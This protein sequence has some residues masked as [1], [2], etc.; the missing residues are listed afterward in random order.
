VQTGS[1]S[2]LFTLITALEK[3]VPFGFQLTFPDG[4]GKRLTKLRRRARGLRR[5][6]GGR[7]PRD[8]LRGRGTTTDSLYTGTT[9]SINVFFAHLEQ[10]VG[11][12]DTVKTAVA[13]VT[14]SDGTSLLKRMSSSRAAR[15][16][17]LDSADSIPSFTLGSVNVSPISM[18]AAYA[19][20]ASNGVYC[21]PVVLT[22]IVDDDGHSLPVIGRYT[23]DPRPGRP[24]GGTTSSRAC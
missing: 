6:P 1:S 17:T 10:K 21:K 15:K 19:V 12:C 7:I 24:G 5:W 14:R 2:K 11:L 18:A 3:G 13:W 23:S 9:A 16:V 4:D 20:P 22:K 8:E